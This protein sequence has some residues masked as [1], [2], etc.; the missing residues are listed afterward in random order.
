MIGKKEFRPMKMRWLLC[1]L[2]LALM[3]PM[4][5]LGQKDAVKAPAPSGPQPVIE[6]T[7]MAFSF[8]DLY[9][10]DKFVHAFTVKNRGKADLVIAEVKPG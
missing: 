7:D 5:V 9:H 2:V 1:V 8:G 10:Q 3:A 4:A 6:I